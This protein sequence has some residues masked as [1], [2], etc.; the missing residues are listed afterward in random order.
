MKEEKFYSEY[1]A[2]KYLGVN[3]LTVRAHRLAGLL[4]AVV[5]RGEGSTSI[6][7]S[8]SSMDAWKSAH[9]TRV[10]LMRGEFKRT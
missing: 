10:R 2:A 3:R 1:G 6:L 9:F 7:I 5:A 4:P 8:K